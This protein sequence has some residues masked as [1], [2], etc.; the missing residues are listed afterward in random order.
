[1]QAVC[2]LPD[3]IEAGSSTL[4]SVT[5][6]SRTISHSA[7]DGTPEMDMRP[8]S[9]P[10][11]ASGQPAPN[12]TAPSKTARARIRELETDRPAPSECGPGLRPTDKPDNSAHLTRQDTE[13]GVTEGSVASQAVG[14]DSVLEHRPFRPFGSGSHSSHIMAQSRSTLHL[15]SSSHSWTHKA[16][17]AGAETIGAASNATMAKAPKRMTLRM[18]PSGVEVGRRLVWIPA[19]LLGQGWRTRLPCRIPSDKEAFAQVCLAAA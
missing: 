11:S 1:M 18:V 15:T 6:S 13:L 8:S 9:A 16:L 10:R 14:Q 4:P 7:H 2:A 19:I 3:A 5:S 12:R 17:D